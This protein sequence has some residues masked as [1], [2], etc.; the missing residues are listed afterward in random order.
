MHIVATALILACAAYSVDGHAAGS[1]NANFNVNITIVD[2]CNVSAQLSG[3]QEAARRSA[4]VGIGN[5][6][7]S[8]SKNTPAMITLSGDVNSAAASSATASLQQMAS[9][10]NLSYSIGADGTQADRLVATVY[11][12]SEARQIVPAYAD[13]VVATVTF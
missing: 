9:R 2:N 6:A 10:S 5:V 11:G 12:A 7:V 4:T 13:T 3:E 1:G 8:C